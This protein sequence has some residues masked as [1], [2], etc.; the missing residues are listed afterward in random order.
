MPRR[1][2]QNSTSGKPKSKINS[3][4]VYQM[5][6]ALFTENKGKIR[7]AIIPV[8]SL[9]QHGSHL[10]VSTDSIIVEYIAKRIAEKI[11]FFVLPVINY[12]VSFE[13][14]PMFNLSIT[15]STLSAIISDICIS[16]VD[17]GIRNILILNGHHGNMGAIQYIAQRLYGRISS[18]TK[19]QF[20]NY[21]H[22]LK[23]R[24]FDHGGYVETSL[25]L[26]ISPNMVNMKRAHPSKK[27]LVNSKVAYTSITNIPGSFP[28][29][30]GNGIWGNPKLAN[31]Q[32][33]KKMIDDIADGMK[34]IVIR[35]FRFNV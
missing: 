34:D 19:V 24:E 13:H 28:S 35:D 29:I 21:W 4:S 26:A 10:P 20:I 1:F 8:G 17:N 31:E 14:S 32:E 15:D 7:N 6:N 33:G 30:T 25:M 27:K 3:I 5:S 22:L 9:E 2:I 18:E 11:P 12:G 16:L 23:N